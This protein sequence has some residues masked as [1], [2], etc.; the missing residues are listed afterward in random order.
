M[1]GSILNHVFCFSSSHFKKEPGNLVWDR[2]FDCRDPGREI[3]IDF[4]VNLTSKNIESHLQQ[5]RTDRKKWREDHS[6]DVR[7]IRSII[8]S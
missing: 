1:F 4:G 2:V 3:A 7:E 5:I 6:G 8:E